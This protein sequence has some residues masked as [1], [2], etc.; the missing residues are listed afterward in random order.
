MN[1]A[2]NYKDL[3]VFA[4]KLLL[5]IGLDNFSANTVTHGLCEASLRGVTSHGIRL[6]PHYVNSALNGRKNPKP[7]F[8]FKKNFLSLGTLD[9]DNAFGHAAGV[10]ALKYCQ[11]M[12]KK[13]GVG[14]VA[15]KNS[16]HPG[17]LASIA[18][19]I[20]KKGYI[21]FAFTHADSLLLSHNGKRPYFG[22]NP[23]CFAAPRQNEEPYCLDMATSMISWNKLLMFRTKKKKLDTQLASDSKGMSTSDPFEAKSLFGAG[24]YKGYGLASMVEVLCGI[25]TGMKFG[26]SIPAMYTTPISKKRKLGQF[27]IV[28]RTDGCISSK[29]FK[30]RMLQLSK[31]IRKEPKKDK[32][33]KVILP[34]DKEIII[35]K[36][37]I[38]KGVKINLETYRDL[39]KLSEKFNLK[40]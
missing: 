34:N 36:R 7:K 3:K 25:Y 11:N 6:L 1:K 21:V 15:V 40:F 22:T 2:I 10:K 19:P 28:I 27:Y 17:A 31:E 37:Q 38:K 8:K 9:A 35:M 23:I 13:T 5:K 24:S 32:K 20:A 26:R 29:K 16:S 30:S 14:I 18:L 4:K 12:A 33:S 39:K